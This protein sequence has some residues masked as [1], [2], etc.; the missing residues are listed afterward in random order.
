MASLYSPVQTYLDEQGSTTKLLPP[1]HPDFEAAHEPSGNN[2]GAQPVLIARPQNAEDVQTMVRYCAQ[3]NVRF[4]VRTGGHNSPGPTNGQ[5][6]LWIDLRDI[7]YVDISED[8]KTVKV[9]GGVLFRRLTET[10]AE[11][12]LLIPS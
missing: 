7:D 4:V 8:K 2:S 6:V 11:D 12:G 5:D 10:L 1:E 3:N 9:G